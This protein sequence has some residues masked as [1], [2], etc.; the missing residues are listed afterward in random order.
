MGFITFKILGDES[1]S[2]RVALRLNKL[3]ANA[4]QSKNDQAS[5]RRK[6]RQASGCAEIEIF[7]EV[8]KKCWSIVL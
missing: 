4:E 8:K 3:M 6:E 7:C 5:M 2:V 1:N